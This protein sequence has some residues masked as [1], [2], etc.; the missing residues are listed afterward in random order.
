M[1]LDRFG[2][3]LAVDIA[4]TLFREVFG[5]D[6]LLVKQTEA[7]EH[8]GYFQLRYW[9]PPLQYDIVLE[10]DRGTFNI[11]IFDRE[12]NESC[13]YWMEEYDGETKVISNMV[14]ALQKLKKHLE[15]N[16]FYFYLFRGE[17]IYRKESEGY[18]RVKDLGKDLARRRG[19]CK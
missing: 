10:N 5:E 17:K 1:R 4:V 2:N 11:D 7:F 12:G 13:L 19:E 16:D 9:Y 15:T 14:N 18:K 3:P 8:M 6:M